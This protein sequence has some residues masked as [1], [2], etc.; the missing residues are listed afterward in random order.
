MIYYTYIQS[1]CCTVQ[2]SNPYSIQI[3]YQSNSIKIIKY[4]VILLITKKSHTHTHTH[5]GTQADTHTR[6]HTHTHARTGTYIHMHARQHE[7]RGRLALHP[8]GGE[9]PSNAAQVAGVELGLGGVHPLAPR[10]VPG[11]GE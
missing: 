8:R 4:Y 3:L 9:G 10:H 2:Y 6:T 11:L 5:T 1:T 7:V